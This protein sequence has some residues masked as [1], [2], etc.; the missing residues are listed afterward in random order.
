MICIPS[1]NDYI[2]ALQANGVVMA[3]KREIRGRDPDQLILVPGYWV[4]GTVISNTELNLPKTVWKNQESRI[5][6]TH[7][8]LLLD[9]PFFQ[10]LTPS[11]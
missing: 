5:S 4:L 8:T 7:V 1:C 6:L 2:S 3:G 11:T 10:E 9:S